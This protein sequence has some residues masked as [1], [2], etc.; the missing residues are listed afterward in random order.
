MLFTGTAVRALWTD[1]RHG[2]LGAVSC[3]AAD[4]AAAGAEVESRR[5]KVVDR[6]WSWLRQVHG[7]KVVVVDAPG[8]MA[9]EVG[10]ALVSRSTDACLAVFS[11]DC[12]TVALASPEGAMGAV[13]AGW[14]G[15]LAGVV[16]RSVDAMRELGASRVLAGLGPC[17]HPSCYEF[18]T[19]D[20]EEV[21]NRLGSSVRSTTAAGS[22]SLD[23][24]EA[25][26]LA[27]E[28]AGAQLIAVEDV[29]TACSAGHFSY[30]ARRDR[31][32]QALVVWRD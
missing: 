3:R 12:A 30:R 21:A 25:V 31:G 23:V 14:R 9:G 16:Q 29:C 5:R 11:A 15:L 22:P 24:P 17:I 7:D 13:H 2:D 10:D 8:G 28:E 32:R 27:L 19:T 1:R 6:S 18:S 4:G 20:L 26:R